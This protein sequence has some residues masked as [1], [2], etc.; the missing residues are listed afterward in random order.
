ML[1]L[2][3]SNGTG[4]LVTLPVGGVVGFVGVRSPGPLPGT[5][6]VGMPDGAPGPDGP[7]GTDG[8]VGCSSAPTG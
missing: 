8:T 5:S 6:N 7:D 4:G 3:G 2:S 1:M